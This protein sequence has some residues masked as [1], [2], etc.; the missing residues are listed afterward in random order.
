M[1]RIV[2]AV[3]LLWAASAHATP[4]DRAAASIARL[5]ASPAGKIVLESTKRHGGLAAWFTGKAL[6]FNYRYAPVGGQPARDSLQTVDLLSS[7]AYHDMVSP[8]KGQLAWDGKQAWSTFDP[9]AAAPRF[10]AL[11]PYY[12][13]GMPFVLGDPG[14]NLTIVNEDPA[15]AG[16]PPAHTVKVTYN[17][18]TGDAPDDYYIAYIAKDDARLLAVRYVVSYKAFMKDGKKHKPEKILIYS[19]FKPAGPLTLARTHSFFKYPGK[20]GDPASNATLSKVKYAAPFDEQRL[21]MPA[22]ARIDTSLDGH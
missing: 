22:G 20:K 1:N 6:Q 3:S 12:F 2:L 11:T 4:A 14:V 21:V 5:E 7:R 10:W 16:L 19:D 13:V 9:K 18:G 17:A 8:V 15:L